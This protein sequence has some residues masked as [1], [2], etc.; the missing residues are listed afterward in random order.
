MKGALSRVRAS[1]IVARRRYYR[2]AA[3]KSIACLTNGAGFHSPRHIRV[4]ES[5]GALEVSFTSSKF[6]SLRCHVEPSSYSTRLVMT[7]SSKSFVVLFARLPTLTTPVGAV[8]VNISRS[9][10]FAGFTFTMHMN[11]RRATF[12][13]FAFS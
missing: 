11:W 7:A 2:P 3:A 9:L 1:D 10:V 6:Q 5:A 12:E 13:G 8:R 4:F